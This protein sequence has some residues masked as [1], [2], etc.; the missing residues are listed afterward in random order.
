LQ[1]HKLF[2]F[3]PSGVDSVQ[4]M[5]GSILLTVFYFVLS[6]EGNF[7]FL[8]CLICRMN[9]ANS[10]NVKPVNNATKKNNKGLMNHVKSITNVLGMGN[11]PQNATAAGQTGGV[12]PV[13]YRYPPNM[14]QPSEAVMEWATTAD[15]PTPLSGM[16]N[17]AHGGRRRRHSRKHRT[18]KH[19]RRHTRKHR[20]HRRKNSHRRSRR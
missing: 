3:K 11:A 12:A 7:N 8:M 20:V 18:S 5:Q 6:S 14:Q 15:A 9:A 10:M 19:K 13:N 16:R 2:F 4:I 1:G 17:V